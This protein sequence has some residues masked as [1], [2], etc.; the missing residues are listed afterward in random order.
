MVVI[1]TLAEGGFEIHETEQNMKTRAVTF[2]VMKKYPEAFKALEEAVAI[3][4]DSTN[5]PD[6]ANYR[7]SLERSAARAAER[8]RAK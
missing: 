7:I 6:I 4:P 2:D 5:I 1:Q 8:E 3:A